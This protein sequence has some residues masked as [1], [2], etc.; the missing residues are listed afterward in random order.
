MNLAREFPEYDCVEAL[1]QGFFLEDLPWRKDCY[2]RYRR[3]GLNA[4][5]GTVVLFQCDGAVV[6]CAE[7]TD[8]IPFN[9][10]RNGYSG[11]FHFKLSSIAV[12]EPIR[13]TALHKVWPEFQ[14]FGQGKISLR[15]SRYPQFDKQL[16]QVRH[17]TIAQQI[18]AAVSKLT[19]PNRESGFSREQVREEVGVGREIW[20][21]SYGPVFQSMRADQPGG[22]P[23]VRPGYR[24]LFRQVKRGLHKLTDDGKRVIEK[25]GGTVAGALVRKTKELTDAEYFE[26]KNVADERERRITEVVQRRG[27]PK[28]R[29]SLLTAYSKQ[30]AVTRCD[31]VAALEAAHIAPY[32]GPNWNHVSNGL[33]L[34]SDIH[35]LFDLNLIGINPD[36]LRIALNSQLIGSSYMK[37]NGRRLARPNEVEHLPNSTVLKQRWNEF[38]SE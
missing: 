16:K 2:Y 12:F 4:E 21:A 18:V 15:A 6:A 22:A 26:P 3:S 25:A 35:A 24:G 7:L 32:R 17:L 8:T 29:R 23:G 30:C 28:F 9:R 20:N 11:Q 33:L 5:P 38:L 1:Q 31:A 36:S 27:Q 13:A 19:Q 14:R 34:R 37:L 10:P